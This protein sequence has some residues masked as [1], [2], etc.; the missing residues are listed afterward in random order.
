MAN[1]TIAFDTLTTSGQITGGTAKS[2]DTDY[3][4]TGSAK[5]WVIFSGADIETP[6][7]RGSLNIASITDNGTGDYNPV[8]TNNMSDADYSGSLTCH[9]QRHHNMNSQTTSTVQLLIFNTSNSASDTS[10][11]RM[12]AIG[13]LA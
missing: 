4:V 1:G 2:V 7:G 12:V 13:D 10:G 5:A 9:S 8:Y 6:S 3:L 11:V